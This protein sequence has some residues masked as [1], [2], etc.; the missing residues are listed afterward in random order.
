MYKLEVSTPE[1]LG[2]FG[3][4]IETHHLIINPAKIGE[5][6]LNIIDVNAGITVTL[7]ITVVDYYLSFKIEDIEGTNTNEFFKTDNYIRFIRN[8]DNTKPVKIM[9]APRLQPTAQLL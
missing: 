8:E 3:I 2:K 5:S 1:V 4:D 6:T 7:D 9:E